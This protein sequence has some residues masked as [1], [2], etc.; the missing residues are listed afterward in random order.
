MDRKDWTA[1]RVAEVL[2]LSASS[3]SRALKLLDLPCTVQEAVEAGTLAPSV[4]YEVSKIQDPD[5]QAE[6]A[7]RVIAEDL[8]RAETVEVVREVAQRKAGGAGRPA[9]GKGRG[10]SKPALKT[11]RVL[12]AAG[13]KV[14]FESR[15]GVDDA[16]LAV[17][18][19]EAL[20][21]VEPSAGDQAAA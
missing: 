6:V 1:D 8:S 2:H 21:Q 19:R 16:L 10:A 17:A 15:R 20:A 9:A 12:K 3:V 5:A 11:S 13:S 14:T 7:A 4:A 18:L